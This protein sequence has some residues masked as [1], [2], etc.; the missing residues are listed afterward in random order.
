MASRRGIAQLPRTIEAQKTSY[1]KRVPRNSPMD[2]WQQYADEKVHLQGCRPATMGKYMYCVRALEAYADISVSEFTPQMLTEHFM[3]LGR[4][5]Q[6]N[7]IDY[8]WDVVR[9]FFQWCVK[10]G[11]APQDP[12]KGLN[13]NKVEPPLPRAVPWDEAMAAVENCW[14]KLYSQRDQAAALL[15][16]TTGAR[17]GE[18]L[19]RRIEDLDLLH[20]TATFT[21][22]K[23]RRPKILRLPKWTRERFEKYLQWRGVMFPDSGW[24]FPGQGGDPL[25]PTAWRQRWREY[26]NKMVPYVMRHT[27]LTEMARKGVPIQVIARQAGHANINTTQKYLTVTDRE[28]EDAADLIEEHGTQPRMWRARASEADGTRTPR[29]ARQRNTDPQPRDGHPTRT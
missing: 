24:L 2:L 5:R 18:I 7:T 6:G 23:G 3:E 9:S 1:V 19:S 25:S 16:L 17:T 4:Q 14:G 21:N 22:T 20:M 8:H 11:Y 27:L 12:F 15:M 29:T 28:M 26:G 13:R 10:R